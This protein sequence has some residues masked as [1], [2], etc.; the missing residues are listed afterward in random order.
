MIPQ[1][2]L[3]R[4]FRS[5]TGGASLP[6]DRGRPLSGTLARGQLSFGLLLGRRS[7]LRTGQAGVW[8]DA[9]SGVA[10]TTYC[11]GGLGDRLR[12]GVSSTASCSLSST[13]RGLARRSMSASART[14]GSGSRDDGV[15]AARPADLQ[16]EGRSPGCG[17]GGGGRKT[18]P[19]PFNLYWFD[20]LNT[21]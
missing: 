2:G 21:F 8:R 18:S 10:S 20:L 4:V 16:P 17:F 6:L 14:G 13:A 3:L 7:T 11:L 12:A 19:S 1:A 5:L 15:V 9:A